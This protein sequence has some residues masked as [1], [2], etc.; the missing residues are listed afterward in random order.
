MARPRSKKQ[1]N[2]D[3]PSNAD[4][5]VANDAIDPALHAYPGALPALSPGLVDSGPADSN[6]A[7]GDDNQA[8]CAALVDGNADAHTGS[9]G[10]VNGTEKAYVAP[11]P[12]GSTAAGWR[13]QLGLASTQPIAN[14]SASE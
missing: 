7:N 5:V 1:K 10:P 6:P 2:T 13:E 9:A 4:T 8:S 3:G 12:A 14:A 11:K